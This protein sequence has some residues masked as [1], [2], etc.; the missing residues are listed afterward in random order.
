[1]I[2]GS[3]PLWRP[4][5]KTLGKHAILWGFSQDYDPECTSSKAPSEA[6]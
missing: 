1:M 5:G 4:W 6:M 3:V 2:H